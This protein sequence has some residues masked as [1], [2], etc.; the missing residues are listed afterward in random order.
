[1]IIISNSPVKHLLENAFILIRNRNIMGKDYIEMEG[2]FPEF[3]SPIL[4]FILFFYSP[5]FSWNISWR[6]SFMFGVFGFTLGM[7]IDRSCRGSY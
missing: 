5:F 1:L 6:L 3:L 4:G 2:G 7:F